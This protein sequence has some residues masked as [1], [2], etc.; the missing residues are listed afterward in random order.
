M[1]H[2]EPRNPDTD[3]ILFTLDPDPPKMNKDPHSIFQFVIKY[4]KCIEIY[5]IGFDP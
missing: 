2:F 1:H 3:I 4:T 5:V